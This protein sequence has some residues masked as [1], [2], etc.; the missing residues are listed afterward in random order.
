MEKN[1]IKRNL[2]LSLSILGILAMLYAFI[3]TEEINNV[4][5]GLVIASVGMLLTQS[6]RPKQ[7][8][9]DE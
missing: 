5:L 1:K 9:K 2:G 8:A 3:T 7:I 6:A 4:L